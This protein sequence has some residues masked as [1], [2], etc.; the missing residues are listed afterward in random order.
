MPSPVRGQA[1]KRRS[2]ASGVASKAGGRKTA[3]LKR[4]KV[5]N[6]AAR[7]S[8]SSAGA[9]GQVARLS[10]ELK[11][12]R[13][14]QTATANVLKVVSHSTFDLAKVLNTVLDAAAHLSAADKG[15]I[16]TPSPNEASFY[17]AASYRHTPEF[18]EHQRSLT[19]APGRSGV[20]GRV[21]LEGKSVQ[22]P[23][24]RTDREYTFRETARL[25]DYRTILG[26]PLL[27]DGNPIGLF[28]LQRAAVRP[29]TDEQIALVETFA[30]QAVI[31][32]ENARLINELRQRTTD[33]T[34]RTTD[35]TEA[36]EQQ[37]ATSDV[38]RVISSSPGDLEPVFAAMLEKA[39]RICNATYGNIYR[40]DGEALHLLAAHN[41]P[42]AFA[43][44]RKRSPRYPGSSTPAGRM[45]ATKTV[46]HV[47][48]L[49]AEP[50][51]VEQHD[52][53]AVAA[54][55]LGGVRTVL[56]VPMLKE[57]ELIGA[58]A[59]ARQEVRPFSDKQVALVTNFAA[60]A[61]IAIE[62]A[63]LLNELRQSFEQQTATAD[64]LRVISSSP[65]ELEPVFQ[66]MLENATRI[67]EAKFGTLYLCDADAFRVVAMHNTPPAYA[68]ARQRE[69]LVRPP[70][71]SLLSRVSASK[72]VVHVADL[73]EVQSYIERN[74]YMT[75]GVELGGYRTVLGV[76]MI[77]QS[78]LIGVVNIYRQEVRPF[79]DKQIELVKNFAA[80]AVIVIENA[81]LLNELRQRTTDLTERT[82][83][84]IEAL[85]QQTATSEVLQV[86]GG[87]PG[88]LRPV[89]ETMLTNAT[90]ICEAKFGV[91]W[92]SEG[93]RFRCVALHNARLR[94]SRVACG[95]YDFF[96]EKVRLRNS[97]P[98]QPIPGA[99]YPAG[100]R[101]LKRH[102]EPTPE[103][104]A[105][106]H[107][108][109]PGMCPP[110]SMRNNSKV[111]R[112]R[113]M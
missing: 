3:K 67:C 100:T 2:S 51:Y 90:R 25:G 91:L 52:P 50:A 70:P 113:A 83:D 47:A 6:E 9:E 69:P 27:R 72:Q 81:R 37:T 42:P 18:V 22:I 12:A 33:L 43:E 89:F 13:E 76:P 10:R 39:V 101:C 64:V 97:V 23:D 16:V 109:P 111:P 87:S 15:T 98:R 79:T 105:C 80:Q 34:E 7:R 28:V 56:D 31:A 107:P 41:T 45:V 73:R 30:D 36:L 44:A 71:D 1:M 21:L 88:D 5:F 75:A 60:Q 108:L 11:E 26:V 86:I 66:A 20:V 82:A 17:V 102:C 24:V 112:I 103:R 96:V 8:S 78:A 104:T 68:E 54:V 95:N 94:F 85:E 32:I 48:D 106:H 99:A 49:A 110:G 84:L 4:R 55:E 77:K 59:L 63:R 35:L 29:F 14:Q 65:G 92:L 40:W 38:L 74:P 93:E 62:N 53:A 46:V 19:Y 61:V 58:F 57:N